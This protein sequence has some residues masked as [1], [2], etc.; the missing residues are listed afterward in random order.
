MNRFKN[1]LEVETDFGSFQIGYGWSYVPTHSAPPERY[2][3]CDEDDLEDD[4]A[5]EVAEDAVYSFV[6]NR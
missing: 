2:T 5:L 6:W 4:H 1:V 3:Y